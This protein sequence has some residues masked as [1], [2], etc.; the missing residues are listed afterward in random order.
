MPKVIKRTTHKRK[1]KWLE[2]N[3]YKQDFKSSFEEPFQASKKKSA[4]SVQ[5]FNK[6]N[7]SRKLSKDVTEASENSSFTSLTNSIGL[8]DKTVEIVR[9]CLSAQK[10]DRHDRKLAQ[11]NQTPTMA[12][13]RYANT[14]PGRGQYIYRQN[15]KIFLHK[16]VFKLKY[17]NQPMTM[18]INPITE[19]RI[20]D[21]VFPLDSSA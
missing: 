13:L 5:N 20:S 11:K 21:Y 15:K 17:I 14:I 12:L 9:K 3:S 8:T 7:F 19:V 6:R 16:K 10:K 18:E 1:T 2:T 4:I